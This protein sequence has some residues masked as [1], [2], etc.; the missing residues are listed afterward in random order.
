MEARPSRGFIGAALG[1]V[2][3][4]M[5]LLAIGAGD[6][7]GHR[8]KFTVGNA[9]GLIRGFD[10][11]LSGEPVGNV[12]KVEL[13]EDYKVDVEVELDE[14]AWPL[15][16]DTTF[17]LRQ[18]GTIKF[19]DRYIEIV[20][21]RATSTFP[22][23]GVVPAA[24]FVNP[25]EFDDVL[26]AFPKDTRTDLETLLENGAGAA[27][28]VQRELGRALRNGADAATATSAVVRQLADDSRALDVLVRSAAGV[29]EAAAAANPGLSELVD[30][31]ARTFTAV[32]TRSADLGRT[33]EQAPATLRAARATAGR[34]DVTLETARRVTDALAPAVAPLRSVSTPLRSTL[35]TVKD[36]GPDAT[37]TLRTLDR[38]APRLTTLSDKVTKPLLPSVEKIGEQ[39][40]V[41]VGCLRPFSPEIG[42][43]AVNWATLWGAA[44]DSMDKIFRAQVGLV[45]YPNETTVS[46]GTVSKLLPAGALRMAFPRPPGQLVNKPWFQPQCGITED[47]LDI[48][49]DPEATGFDPMSKKIVELGG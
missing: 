14:V 23:G 4:V 46:S 2:V 28:G 15:P 41:Q 18:G 48:S 39:A 10:V 9:T 31:A 27:P 47:A 33:L 24:R 29:S 11:R 8:L 42:G 7:D 45:P 40:A 49:K 35:R 34:V 20:R 19:S 6:P 17:R 12:A 43:L 3:V 13:R 44:G 21:G 1:A 30:T 26:N 25:V 36:I 38:A 37:R 32:A 5:L 16:T 22:D